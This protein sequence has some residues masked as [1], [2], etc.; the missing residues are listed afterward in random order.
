LLLFL[1]LDPAGNGDPVNA[2]GTT[3][4]RASAVTSERL[5]CIRWATSVFGDV[6]FAI[7]GWACSRAARLKPDLGL[8]WD[9]TKGESG[10]IL[11]GPAALAESSCRAPRPNLEADDMALL[12]GVGCDAVPVV[13]LSRGICARLVP[14]HFPLSPVIRGAAAGVG[15][16]RRACAV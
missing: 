12:G 7:R 6:W 3:I 9:V 13:P 10:A 14:N 4:E 8:D 15:S 16:P 1:P 2:P 5:F 11:L